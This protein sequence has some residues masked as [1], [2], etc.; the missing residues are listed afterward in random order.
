MKKYINNLEKNK[1]LYNPEI[2]KIIS[3]ISSLKLI[4]KYK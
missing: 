1:K 4:N 2:N 3:T